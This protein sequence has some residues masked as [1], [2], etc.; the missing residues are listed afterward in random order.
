MS[1]NDSVIGCPTSHN[2]LSLVAY[3]SFIKLKSCLVIFLKEFLH[4]I[5]RCQP[6]QWL[7]SSNSM[8]EMQIRAVYVHKMLLPIELLNQCKIHFIRRKLT[9]TNQYQDHNKEGD[10]LSQVFLL[11]LHNLQTIEGS[12]V[13][14]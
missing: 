7:V 12:M 13:N 1:A 14:N 6:K 2:R 5:L 3:Y 10:A 8:R 9:K 4:N 11:Q